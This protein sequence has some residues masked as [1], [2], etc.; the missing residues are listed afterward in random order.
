[1]EAIFE[2]LMTRQLFYEM[3][4]IV[5]VEI[6]GYNSKQSLLLLDEML[7]TAFFEFYFETAY[8]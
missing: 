3:S 8:L 1:M 4:R 2:A 6:M 7:A 5:F